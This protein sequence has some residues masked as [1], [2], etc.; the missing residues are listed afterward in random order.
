M[1]TR[2]QW[3]KAA[4]EAA[5]AKYGTDHAGWYTFRRVYAVPVAVLSALGAAGLAGYLLWH[6]VVRP[7]FSGSG[8]HVA[9]HL[10]L[11]FAMVA[12]ALLVVT[13]VAFRP[14][15]MPTIFH[16][17]VIKLFVVGSA[18]LGLIGYLIAHLT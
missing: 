5:A 18:W 12:G 14:K 16:I 8:P 6:K 10:G 3:N 4:Q 7:M 17:T 1:I 11:G 13:L 15:A 2:E 9:G